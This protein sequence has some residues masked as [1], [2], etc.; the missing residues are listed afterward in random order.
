MVVHCA[1]LWHLPPTLKMLADAEV[2]RIIAFGST[3]IFAKALS[4]N[5]L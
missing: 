2:K 3:S 5:W 4:R 1:P